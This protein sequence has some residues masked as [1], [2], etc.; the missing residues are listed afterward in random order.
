[1]GPKCA[2]QWEADLMSRA[3]AVHSSKDNLNGPLCSATTRAGW[4]RQ[5]PHGMGYSSLTDASKVKT[6]RISFTC[7]FL[8][9]HVGLNLEQNSLSELSRTK[10]GDHIQPREQPELPGSLPWILNDAFSREFACVYFPGL[11]EEETRNCV[12]Y[13]TKKRFL[14]FTK[15]YKEDRCTTNR[16]SEKY[17]GNRV[18]WALYPGCPE[19]ARHLTIFHMTA[20]SSFVFFCWPQNTTCCEGK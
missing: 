2:S 14:F 6:H 20:V 18:L 9:S 19:P 16:L 13:E 1:M 11:T 3:E 4:R 17:K 5:D 15:T 8:R 12:R 10:A 7:N